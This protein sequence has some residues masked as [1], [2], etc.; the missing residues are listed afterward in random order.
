MSAKALSVSEYSNVLLQKYLRQ[1]FGASR[2]ENLDVA[3]EELYVL[4]RKLK[5]AAG[6]ADIKVPLKAVR[7]AIEQGYQQD[8]AGGGDV[9]LPGL[10]EALF[11]LLE[12][13]EL[14]CE[15]RMQR[16][17]E[18][19]QAAQVQA[20]LRYRL[21][22]LVTGEA[23]DARPSLK[24]RTLQLM[25]GAL[26][27]EK[28]AQRRQQEGGGGAW[29][30]GQP[31][32]RLG[33]TRSFGRQRSLGGSGAGQAVRPK[34]QEAVDEV[35]KMQGAKL[36]PLM[37]LLLIEN[38]QLAAGIP[39]GAAAAAAGE[40]ALPHS[41][42]KG[43]PQ[44]GAVTKSPSVASPRTPEQVPPLPQHAQQGRMPNLDDLLGLN[45]LPA[46]EA[47][48]GGRSLQRSSTNTSSSSTAPRDD[49]FAGLA[50]D[51]PTGMPAGYFEAFT[52]P[53]KEAGWP[54]VDHMTSQFGSMGVAS[55][56]TGPVSIPQSVHAGPASPPG[57]NNLE[58]L[59]GPSSYP[60]YLPQSA[61]FSPSS[62]PTTTSGNYTTG[63]ATAGQG[64]T[65]VP[66][67][68][69]QMASMGTLG[70]GQGPK[71]PQGAGSSPSMGFGGPQG[72]PYQGIDSQLAPNVA[73][74]GMNGAARG[75]TPS[76]A[77]STASGNAVYRQDSSGVNRAEVPYDTSSP[78][79][80]KTNPF[81]DPTFAEL[82]PMR[83]H[84]A[85][86]PPPTAAARRAAAAK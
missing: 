13:L 27:R 52:S 53:Q 42:N 20:I 51:R 3:A 1:S 31:P 32:L 5:D 85:P 47:G 66:P 9:E 11:Q 77:S 10:V 49:P 33:R 17:I 54:A 69:A 37:K 86:P 59:S 4:L 46:P 48:A 81:I 21:T 70:S 35:G 60:T 75:G 62:V 41:P 24:L 8:S 67:A 55:A 64:H 39:T 56:V 74:Q 82:S 22:R 12:R 65:E 38:H 79:F 30:G 40:E 84:R 16:G 68:F 43:Y 28:E 57:F 50:G 80:G 29:E 63:A 6:D 19:E 61:S 78:Y 83:A 58:G 76:S 71:G 26:V 44:A 14:L 18:A 73:A 34:W 23:W 36:L 72:M 15:E 25:F 45:Q 7:S 2:Q